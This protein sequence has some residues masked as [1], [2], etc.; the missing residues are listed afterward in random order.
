[1]HVFENEVNY[2]NPVLDK[3]F[4]FRFRIIKF[5]LHVGRRNKN[6]QSI[7]KQILR[8]GTSVGAN[9]TEAQSAVTKKRFY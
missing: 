9:I 6:I 1:M 5:Y 4:D 8:C 3:S 7:L 2:N